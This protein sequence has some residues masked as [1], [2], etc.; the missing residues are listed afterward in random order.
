[1]ELEPNTSVGRMIYILDLFA[2]KYARKTLGPHGLT[3]EQLLY[4]GSLIKKGD[5]ITQDELAGR[6]YVDKSTTA[7]MVAAMERDGL[8]RRRPVPNN[9]RA[10]QVWVTERG[11]ETWRV[12]AGKLWQWQSVLLQDF[13][14]DERDTLIS[15]L[16]RMEVNAAR[17]WSRDFE[18]E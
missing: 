15:M 3:K 14:D 12:I 10:N 2:G 16:Q 5:G 18:L 1:M 11:R 6:L 13:S 4:L 9:A 7:R 17:A 8:V